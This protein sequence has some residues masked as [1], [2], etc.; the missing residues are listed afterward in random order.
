MRSKTS[1]RVYKRFEFFN[2]RDLAATVAIDPVRE[3][4]PSVRS[5]NT[6]D[7]QVDRFL[8]ISSG[9]VRQQ[10]NGLSRMNRPSQ[11]ALQPLLQ[12][13]T[14]PGELSSR[15]PRVSLTWSCGS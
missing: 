9:H 14:I 10:L 12:G 5:I 4:S 13:A 2:T 3:T 6:S 1:Q 8:A 7:G 11:Q 15:D